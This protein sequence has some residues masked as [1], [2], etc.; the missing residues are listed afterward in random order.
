[1]TLFLHD[2]SKPNCV[3]RLKPQNPIDIMAYP[4]SDSKERK[5]LFGH[6]FENL[7][8]MKLLFEFISSTQAINEFIL[9]A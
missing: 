5:H 4:S 3:R 1:L 2:H 8:D 7:M 9:M 6:A